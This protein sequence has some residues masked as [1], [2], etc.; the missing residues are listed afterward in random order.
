MSSKDKPKKRKSIFRFFLY[1]F[2]KL[3]GAIGAYIWIKPRI[4]Y[5]SDDAKRTAYKDGG[6]VIANHTGVTDPIKLEWA[7]WNRRFHMLAFKELFENKVRNFF[8]SKMLCIPVDR[9]NFSMNTF[10]Q[11]KE[12]TKSGYLVGIFPEG[13]IIREE[14]EVGAFKGGAVMMALRSNVPIIPVYCSPYKKFW[15]FS[16]IVIGEP[17]DVRGL[18]GAVPPL[19]AIEKV[20]EHI[21][22]KEIELKKI[23]EERTGKNDN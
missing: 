16:D 2:V 22:E 10:N 4:H 15:A 11:V 20:T 8:F 1:D 18:C 12:L 14:G 3:T 9:D 19:N 21:R 6:I 13:K 7:F 5:V 17:I 23:Y